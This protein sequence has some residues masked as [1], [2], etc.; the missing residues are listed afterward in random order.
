MPFTRPSLDHA[1]VGIVDLAQALEA[2]AG[3]DLKPAE[4]YSPE[5]NRRLET[6]SNVALRAVKK[7]APAGLRNTERLLRAAESASSRRAAVIWIRRAADAWSRALSPYAA[8][9]VGCDHCCHIPLLL[10]AP[11]AEIIGRGIGRAP[12]KVGK[13]D[14]RP[15]IE[16]YSSPCPF[17]SDGACTIR[18]H[19]PISCR[20]HFNMDADDFLCRLDHAAPVPY[21]DN[22]K[23]T[24]ALIVNSG[25]TSVLADIRQWFPVNS[26]NP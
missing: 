9:K 6:S 11:E 17:L 23:I 15:V 21:A 7:V 4:Q 16:G 13:D 19:R 2:L 25:P 14:P 10:T 12:A 5:V 26:S 24:L 18:E 20:S 22:T 1:G 8:C 3:K